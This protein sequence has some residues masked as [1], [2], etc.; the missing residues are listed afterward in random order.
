MKCVNT[1]AHTLIT[2]MAA[3]GIVATTQQGAAA[4][5]K[6][7]SK[8]LADDMAK[9]GLVMMPFD[10]NYKQAR[11]R[12]IRHFLPDETLKAHAK[13][14]TP[15][16]LTY[17]A[18]THALDQH[19]HAVFAGKPSLDK[20]Q[21]AAAM[22]ARLDARIKTTNEQQV[23]QTGVRFDS[24]NYDKDDYIDLGEYQ[25]TG[26]KSFERY[27]ADGNGIINEA[28]QAVAKLDDE[29]LKKDM[30]KRTRIAWFLSM[31][32]HHSITG[33]AKLYQTNGEALTQADYLAYRE[34]KFF[35]AD[36]DANQKLDLQEYTTEFMGRVAKVVD[37][38]KQNHAAFAN[39]LFGA[40]DGDTNG[41]LT[42]DEFKAYQARVFAYFD[43][44]KDSVL[45]EV[46]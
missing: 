14:D 32:T 9:H 31:P 21:F 5:A 36:L 6:P 42:T 16:N 7:N 26:L 30:P 12:Y 8:A 43:A 22:S 44:N 25:R 10:D 2:M 33:F 20:A 38:T 28:D 13:N 19:M 35:K 15:D 23:K 45:D 46:E 40:A 27:D 41:A 39:Q 37:T 1:S 24:I 3:I 11:V 34:N 29:A 18:F 4:P 17:K